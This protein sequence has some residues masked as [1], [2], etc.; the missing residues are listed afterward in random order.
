MRILHVMTSRPDLG[1]VRSYTVQLSNALA[2][3]GHHLS[4][5][6]Y[7]NQPPD[8]S[9]NV[10]WIPIR[11]G[12]DLARKISLL[13]PGNQF[14]LV[15]TH[16]RKASLLVSLFNCLGSAKHL[17]TLHLSDIPMGFPH[18]YLSSF[19]DFTHSPSQHGVDWLVATCGLSRN[20][21][22]KIPHG[23]N[24]D[25]NRIVSTEE[26]Q[27]ARQALGLPSEGVI[28]AYVGRFEYP[29]NEDWVI[30][31]SELMPEV[32][33]V[34]M[35]DGPNRDQLELNPGRAIILDYGD[36][37]HLYAASDALLLP[38]SREGFSLVTAEAMARGRPTLRTRTAG[39]HETIIEMQ[40]GVS[41]EIEKAAF[42]NAAKIFL[43]DREKLR[44]M[45]ANAAKFAH[46][47]LSHATQVKR[48][49]ELYESMVA[50]DVGRLKF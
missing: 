20:R 13:V 16:F 19:G 36:P 42:I 37:A 38:S 30:E 40:T 8:I 31:L 33:F 24:L 3:R 11:S 17:F 26:Q 21:V 12:L 44:V 29:K 39:V 18:N 1:G 45:G 47:F 50:C 48:T 43:S 14:D 41:C 10:V 22:V 15:H 49:E 9:S 34:L 46:N 23:V 25:Q 7:G 2:E 35:G 28:A 32:T 27:L 5:I 4:I 6:G